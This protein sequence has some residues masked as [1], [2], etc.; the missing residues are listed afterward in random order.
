MP[1]KRSSSSLGIFVG[2][3]LVVSYHKVNQWAEDAG[4]QGRFIPEV[5]MYVPF[6]LF[7]ALILWMF[8]T[9]ATKPGGQPIGALERG[10]AKAWSGIKRLLPR[11]K[12]RPAGA[13][14]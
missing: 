8:T 4:A 2:I 13:P 6:F 11:P 12:R 3:V 14:A 1:P 5:V 9:L 7:A 10:G